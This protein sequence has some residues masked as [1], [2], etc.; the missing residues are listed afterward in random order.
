MSPD[1]GAIDWDA[2]F[3]SLVATLRP[4]RHRRYARAAAQVT[5]AMLLMAMA[6]WTV[7]RLI[8]APLAEMGRP[9]L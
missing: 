4:P 3:E 1:D 7:V 5:A 8:A 9:W 2:A 6:C